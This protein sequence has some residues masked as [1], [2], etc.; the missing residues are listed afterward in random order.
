VFFAAHGIGVERVLTDN[1]GGYVSGLFTAAV[2]A[3]GATH[4]RIRP[5]RPQTNGKVER[6]N[7]TLLAEWAY[8]QVYTS[9]QQRTMA[10]DGWLHLYN[11]HRAHTALGGR[12]PIS[13]VNNAAG[14]Y[15]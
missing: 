5:Y 2:A 1:A 9:N 13:R 14:S 6:F 7:R 10:L 15:T 8:V 3:G 11:H 12:P 4:K